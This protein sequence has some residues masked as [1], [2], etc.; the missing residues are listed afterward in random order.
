MVLAVRALLAFGA[1][2]AGSVSRGLVDLDTISPCGN[3]RRGADG[4]DTNSA[5]SSCPVAWLQAVPMPLLNERQVST[6]NT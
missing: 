3:Y 4:P 6:A 5:V 2:G 1:P